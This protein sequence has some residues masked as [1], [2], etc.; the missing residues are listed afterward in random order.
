MRRHQRQHEIMGT[1]R[2]SAAVEE[3]E[4]A[5]DPAVHAEDGM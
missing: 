5:L 1:N 4:Q 3:R 2:R